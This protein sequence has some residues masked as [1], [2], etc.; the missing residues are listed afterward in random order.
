M[1]VSSSTFSQILYE[2]DKKGRVIREEIRA[3]FPPA[4]KEFS[5]DPKLHVVTHKV[6]SGKGLLL[7]ETQNDDR[8]TVRYEYRYSYF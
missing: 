4:P 8:S 2:Y 6:Y 5:S 7:T 1:T 3:A